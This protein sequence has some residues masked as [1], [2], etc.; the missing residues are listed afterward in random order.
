MNSLLSCNSP[1]PC[2]LSGHFTLSSAGIKTIIKPETDYE[3]YNID[4]AIIPSSLS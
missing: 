1:V 3:N 4:S 2:T